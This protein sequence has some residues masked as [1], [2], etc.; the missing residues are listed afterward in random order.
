MAKIVRLSEFQYKFSI[1]TINENFD[2]FYAQFLKTDLGKIYLSM[3]FSELSQAFKLKDSNK[4]THCYF[5]PKGKI[6]LM[7]LKNYYGCS[8][9]KLI[10]LLNGNIFMQ[11]FCDILIPIDKPLTNF[12]IVSQIRM[13]LSKG[14]NIRKSQEILAKNWIPYMSDLDKIFTDATCYESEV[15]FPTNQKLLWECVQWN[16][17]QMEALCGMLKIKLPRTKYLDWCRRYNEYSKKRKKQSKHRTKVTRGLLKLLYKLNAE[18]NKIENQNSFEATKKYKNQRSLIAKVYQQQSQIFKTGKSVPDRIISISKSYIRPIVRGKEVKQVEFGAKVN[19]I[20][21]DGINF[22]EHIQYRAFNEGTR[23]QS[24]V[25][26]AQNLTKTKV[27][28][29]GADAIY[30]T[31]KN[32]TFTTSNNIQTDFVRKGKAGKNEE[33]RK[34]LAKE[35]KKERSTRLEGSFGKEKEHYNLKKIKA[36]TQKSEMLWIFFGIHTGNAL[37]IG[38]RILKQQ[39]ILAA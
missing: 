13:E 38:R 12:K 22:I 9:K 4:G 3:P 29:L 33:Q 24:T 20:Q 34:I 23:L 21:I 27:K 17:K 37:E 5:S 30:A 1:F 14:L 32:R 31:N 28:M 16:Y 18:L 8:D 19:K 11:F 7:M 35:I 39:Q 2:S 15:R 36:K 10:E 25:F 6:A 26:C